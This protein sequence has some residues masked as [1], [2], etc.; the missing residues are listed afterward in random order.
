MIGIA[1]FSIVL[2]YFIYRG[3]RLG[4]GLVL[5]RLASLIGGYF[6]AV[7][8][9]AK[10]AVLLSENTQLQ[11][12]AAYFVA[13]LAI[14]IISAIVI[15]I[16][17]RILLHILGKVTEGKSAL[18]IPG[19]LANGL[20]GVFVGLGLVWFANMA[21]TALT[22][23]ELPA[24]NLVNNW[25]QRLIGNSIDTVLSKQF[26]QAPQLVGVASY[27]LKN[28]ARS[29]KDGIALSNNPDVDRLIN[30]KKINRMVQQRN[31]LGL[32]IA[33]EINAVLDDKTVQRI[34]DETNVLGDV[35]VTDKTAVKMR[36]T[37]EVM[38]TILRVEAVK[39]NPR[40][41]K[42]SNDP[43]INRMLN[44]GD[45]FGLMNSPKVKEMAQIIMDSGIIK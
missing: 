35:D 37:K 8:Y 26:S 31:V 28:P 25:S 39:Q 1:L 44:K 36:L 16:V 24:D 45:V 41:K 15:S 40:F 18:P 10:G 14:F 5:A 29:I 38:T 23:G 20:I 43:Q 19:A 3:Y 21:S 17:L 7:N 9:A 42:L 12:L 30:S 27:V 33:P 6:L 11:G 34:L 4:L 13:G 2:L 22:N 32:M